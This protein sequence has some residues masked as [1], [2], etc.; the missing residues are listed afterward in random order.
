[1]NFVLGFGGVWRHEPPDALSIFIVMRVT[2]SLSPAALLCTLMLLA[3]SACKTGQRVNSRGPV[4]DSTF[5]EV[6]LPASTP[7][8]GMAD[9]R[10]EYLKAYREGY[11]SGMLMSPYGRVGVAD[12]AEQPLVR[13]WHDGAFAARLAEAMRMKKE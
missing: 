11:S 5:V 7:F 12:A 4:M 3:A 2:T 9:A 13:G 1:M 8:D 6:P 10:A